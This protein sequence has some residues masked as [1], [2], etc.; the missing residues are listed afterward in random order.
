MLWGLIATVGAIKVIQALLGP[1]S[2]RPS[3]P[4]QGEKH[5]P[6]PKKDSAAKESGAKAV[7][8]SDSGSNSS[9]NSRRKK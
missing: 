4:A 2:L 5:K 3:P 6:A 1:R 8:S 9:R 7:P